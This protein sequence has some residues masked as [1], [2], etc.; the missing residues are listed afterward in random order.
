MT[1][2]LHKH[3]TLLYDYKSG[4]YNAQLLLARS[5]SIIKRRYTEWLCA[6]TSRGIQ[7]FVCIRYLYVDVWKGRP[8]IGLFPNLLFGLIKTSFALPRLGYNLFGRLQKRGCVVLSEDYRGTEHKLIKII[9]ELSH[10]MAHT[11]PC[12]RRNNPIKIDDYHNLDNYTVFSSEW[13]IDQQSSVNAQFS[14]TS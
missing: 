10:K 7:S 14:W 5:L 13:I 6:A 11:A 12:E 9:I 1:M 3:T 2:L 4:H 8:G